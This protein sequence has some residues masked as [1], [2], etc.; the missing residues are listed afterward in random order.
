MITPGEVHVW[1]ASLEVGPT[2]LHQ[3]ATTLSPAERQRAA[4][5]TDSGAAAH[6][7]IARGMLREMLGMYLAMPPGAVVLEYEEHGKPC[8]APHC[9]LSFNLSH[10]HGQAIIAACTGGRVGVDLERVRNLQHME[11]IARR[12]FQQDE[13]DSWLRLSPDERIHGF[14]DRWTKLEAAVKLLG[15][16]VWRMLAIGLDLSAQDIHLQQVPVADGFIAALAHESANPR[17][18]IRDYPVA[19]GVR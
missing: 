9:S 17:V 11:R 16:G 8:L 13:L 3:L 15:T 1:R 10:A 2:R 14:F 4:R 12:T 5:I 19:R 6:F 7:T 18:R